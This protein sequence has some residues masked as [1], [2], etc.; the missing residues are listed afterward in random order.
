MR[1]IIII[2]T[3]HAGLTPEN[4]LKEVLEKYSPDQLLVEIVEEDVKKEKFDSYPPEMIFVYKWAKK[5]KIKVNGFDSK[6]DVFSKGM[7][8]EDNEKVIQEQKILMNNLNLKWKDMNKAENLKKL[9]TDSAKKLVDPEK[10]AKRESEMLKN[11][12]KSMIR[13][14]T[15]VIITGCG[16]LEFLERHIK[17]AIFPF[18]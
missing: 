9:D 16:H 14:G 10:E 8:E 5:N 6:I 4:E 7:A 3:L 12:K 18:R 15:I 1:K 17:D 2:G 13:G 11:I